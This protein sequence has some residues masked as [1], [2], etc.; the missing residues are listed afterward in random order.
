ML[1]HRQ[2]HGCADACFFAKF[3]A[4]GFRKGKRVLRVAHEKRTRPRH[5]IAGKSI[6]E[7]AELMACSGKA[8]RTSG[9]R[10]HWRVTVITT[11]AGSRMAQCN[12]RGGGK[13]LV[14]T[15]PY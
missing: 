2:D 14:G 15:E 10:S 8:R 4:T 7:P 13:P 3:Q 11:Q 9:H 5:A 1:A 6:A 12:A